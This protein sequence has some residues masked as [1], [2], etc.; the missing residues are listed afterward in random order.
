MKSNEKKTEKT[1]TD[2]F[3]ASKRFVTESRSW[4]VT[5]REAWL[6]PWEKTSETNELASM[7]VTPWVQAT[8]MTHDK[9]LEVFETQS[10]QALDRTREWVEQVER[11][12][13]QK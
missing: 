4:A 7:M 3:E 1:A 6:A 13:P 8:R 11:M 9:M 10:H 5:L 2:P 12:Q